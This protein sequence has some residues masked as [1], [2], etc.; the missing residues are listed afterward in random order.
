MKQTEAFKNS[1][2]NNLAMKLIANFCKESFAKTD[3]KLP[4]ALK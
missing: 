2:G 4:S 3:L 1:L